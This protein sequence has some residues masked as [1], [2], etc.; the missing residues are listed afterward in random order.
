MQ[1][2]LALLTYLWVAA[3]RIRPRRHAADGRNASRAGTARWIR[4][5]AASVE[6][7][8]ESRSGKGK[9]KRMLPRQGEPEGGVPPKA[10]QRFPRAGRPARPAS[11]PFGPRRTVTGP[12][13]THPHK[14]Q[15]LH[16]SPADAPIATCLP[17][18]QSEGESERPV[19]Q[20]GDCNSMGGVPSRRAKQSSRQAPRTSIVT[21]FVT[22]P[23]SNRFMMC[24]T[25][26]ICVKRLIDPC[27][28]DPITP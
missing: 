25:D 22:N 28:G 19:S 14:R 21:C 9:R 11:S 27:N 13:E 15:K 10:D 18:C 26:S 6:L 5:Q 24:G 4:L 8:S 2:F 3:D 23:M 7:G 12:I 17:P 16:V 1:L 20:V